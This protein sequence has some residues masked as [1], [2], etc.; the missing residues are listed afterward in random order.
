[1]FSKEGHQKSGGLSSPW[2][3]RPCQ[4][5]AA[6]NSSH[7]GR[8]PLAS[9]GQMIVRIGQAWARVCHTRFLELAA[10]LPLPDNLIGKG[11]AVIWHVLLSS[12]G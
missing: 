11:R 1:M 3:P 5:D 12:L 8:R 7:S 9:S 2:R 6:A 4:K 10:P